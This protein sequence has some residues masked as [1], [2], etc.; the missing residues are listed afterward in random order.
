MSY[1]MTT[2]LCYL[3]FLTQHLNDKYAGCMLGSFMKQKKFVTKVIMSLKKRQVTA[4]YVPAFKRESTI[5]RER[6]ERI[7]GLAF[8]NLKLTPYYPFFE[9]YGGDGLHD[10]IAIYNKDDRMA[11]EQSLLEECLKWTDEHPEEVAAH[12][13]SVKDEIARLERHKAKVAAREKAEKE[14]LAKKEAEEKAL[15]KEILKNREEHQRRKRK[16]NKELVDR[17]CV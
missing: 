4:E 12:M 15:E 5:I 8:D 7:K 1:N 14:A 11:F 3:Y 10:S 17:Y 13:E 2:V 9:K 16:L 6:I